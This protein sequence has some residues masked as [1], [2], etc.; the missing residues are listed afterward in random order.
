M[1]L[2]LSLC[3]I[4]VNCLFSVTKQLHMLQQNSY[5]NSRYW[6][7]L[8][9]GYS[10]G[11]QIILLIDLAIKAFFLFSGYLPWLCLIYCG[12]SCL[13][14]GI[15]CFWTQKHAIKPLVFTARVKRM[16][17]TAGLLTAF[18][19][20][21]SF[22]FPSLNVIFFALVLL[23]QISPLLTFL[24]NGLNHPLES[25]IRLYY[26]SDAKKNLRSR[27]NLIVVG[28]TGSYG[29]TS[30]K[31][32]LERLLSEKYNVCMT[33][34]SFNTTLGV[35]RT[36]REHMKPDCQLFLC[37]MGAKKSGDIKE[38]CDIVHPQ[39]G[40][41][42]SV[43]P[44][45]LQTFGTVE[46]VCR[47]KFELADAVKLAN[48]TVFLNFD[49]EYILQ[50]AE[51]YPKISY[52]CNA[53]ADVRA[54]NISCNR[55][56]SSFELCIGDTVIPVTTKLLGRHNILNVLAAAAVA[57]ELGVSE[58]DI[59]YAI[60][61]LSATEHRLQMK[62]FFGGSLLIDDAYN[63][64]PEGSREA[65][66]VLGSF[67]GM[68]KIIVTPGMIELG[69]KEYEYN[70]Q[71]G[72]QMARQ[73]DRIYAVGKNHAKPF[74]DAANEIGFDSEQLIVAETFARALE[75]LKKICDSN[76]VVLFENDLPDNYA[77]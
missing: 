5:F 10:K 4:V 54:Q 17:L 9:H 31:Y 37:E 20:I 66:N 55:A 59:K 12:F 62:P 27:K 76:T 1:L 56:G 75:D 41:I 64:N 19:T 40:V 22:V 70:Y 13:I 50:K 77:G 25:L 8:L 38:I 51:E 60:S 69:E 68:K 23:F 34:G 33:P 16:Y 52:G 71:L 11:D 45:H 32:I 53:Q 61:Q 67:D 74:V 58:L 44:Q 35:V 36:V 6:N 29:K 39:Y 2:H 47:T 18:P 43:G 65:V 57:H 30:T 48:G 3:L 28:V 63:S 26:I 21:F 7:W 46:N 42:T 73:C 14:A 24:V 72:L 15:R 49:N